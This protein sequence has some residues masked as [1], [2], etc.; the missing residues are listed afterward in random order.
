MG[1]YTRVSVLVHGTILWYYSVLTVPSMG[2]YT[3]VSVLVYGTIVYCTFDGREC[4]RVSV[5]V[6]GTILWY[7]SVLYLRWASILE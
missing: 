6:Y 2:E 5:L 3:R 1:E 7:Y 4:T